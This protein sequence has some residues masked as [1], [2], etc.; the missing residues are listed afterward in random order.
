[1]TGD[2]KST[3]LVVQR[4]T[5]DWQSI[6]LDA[7]REQSRSFCRLW[8]KPED[9]VWRLRELWDETYAMS[10][11]QTRAAL[12]TQSEQQ[13]AGVSG[14]TFVPFQHYQNIALLDAPCLFVDD[15]DWISPAIAADLLPQLP[16]QYDALLWRAVN[17]GSPQ[18]EYPMFVWGMNGRCMTNNYALNGRWLQ[19]TGRLAD[20]IQHFDAMKAMATLS[21]VPQ[22]DLTITATNK[23]PCSSV[24]L[25]R[26]LG[27]DLRPAKL[28]AMVDVFLEKMLSVREQDVW[29]AP[30]V[31]PLI[32]EMAAI[33][34]QVTNSRY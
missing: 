8:S 12:K 26:G 18:Q 30:W 24:S 29:Q 16:F 10:Y 2:G 13:V 31:L 6:S 9:Y 20:F 22:L 11:L 27:G 33:F 19:Q 23:S 4:Q 34:Q 25:D 17:I 21:Q 28:A 14:V 5:V 32:Q 3:V 1:M 15:D 7:F